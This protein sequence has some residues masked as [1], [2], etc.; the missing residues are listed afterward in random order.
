MVTWS[1]EIYGITVDDTYARNNE[2]VDGDDA[3]T[4]LM[5]TIM[6]MIIADNDIFWP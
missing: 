4:R 6:I 2:Y 3:G 1:G 5:K